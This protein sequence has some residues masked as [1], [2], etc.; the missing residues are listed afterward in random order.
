[1]NNG[2]VYEIETDAML[3]QNGKTW[4]VPG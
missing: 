1:M 2:E 3:I 4:W